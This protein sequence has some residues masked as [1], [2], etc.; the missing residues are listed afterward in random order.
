MIQNDKYIILDTRTDGFDF[1][2]AKAQARDAIAA[3]PNLNCMVGLFAYSPPL[4]LEAV[5]DAS[6]IG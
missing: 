1:N 6:K 5:R 4:I 3:Y 2:K